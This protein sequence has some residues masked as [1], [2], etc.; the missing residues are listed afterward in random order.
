MIGNLYMITNDINEKVYIGKTYTPLSDR[1]KRHI[2]DTY[3]T[4]RNNNNK[5]YN[6]IRKY[7]PEHFKIELIDKFE[8]GI[9]EQKEQ[10]YIAKYDSYHNGYNST[11]GGDGIKTSYI[12]EDTDSTQNEVTE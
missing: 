11:L 3:R 1:W 10:E 2:K 12:D 7:G 6:A 5:F 9:L 4:D 8:E